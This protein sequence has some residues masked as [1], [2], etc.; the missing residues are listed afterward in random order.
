MEIF[1][2]LKPTI[3]TPDP[4]H[5]KTADPSLVSAPASYEGLPRVI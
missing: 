1:K 5:K 4:S 2:V 3:F